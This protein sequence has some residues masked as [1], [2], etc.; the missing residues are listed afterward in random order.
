MNA[1]DACAGKSR[2]DEAKMGGITPDGVHLE[3]QVRALPAVHA[4]ADHALGVLH[5]DAPLRRAP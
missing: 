2:I 1:R 4:P 3:R 5:R